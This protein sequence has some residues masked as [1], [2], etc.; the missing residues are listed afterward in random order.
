MR[1]VEYSSKDGRVQSILVSKKETD[2]SGEKYLHHLG[3]HDLETQKPKLSE[4]PEQEL[5]LA[6]DLPKEPRLA[7]LFGKNLVEAGDREGNYS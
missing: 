2:W 5:V 1:R 6:E 4:L 7:V 3:L